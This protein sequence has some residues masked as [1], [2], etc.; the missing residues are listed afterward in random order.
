MRRRPF[1]QMTS[2][3]VGSAAMASQASAES[4]GSEDSNGSSL[5]EIHIVGTGG[6]IANPPGEGYYTAEELVEAR[7]QLADLASI[8]VTGVSRV[9]SQDITSEILFETYNVI[10]DLAENPNPP[11]GFVVTTGSNGNEEVGYFLNLALKTDIPVV[12][13]AAQRGVDSPGTD[14]DKNLLDAVRVASSTEAEGRGVLQVANDEIHHTRDVTKLVTTRPD[15]WESPN[16]GRVGMLD[17]GVFFYKSTDRLSTT[18]TEFDISKAEPKDYP[19]SGI[20]TVFSA[21]ESDATLVDA[22]VEADADGIVAVT[23]PTGSASDP[24]GTDS[25]RDGLLRA[26]EQGVPVVY[27]HRGIEG[28][29]TEDDED[30]PIIG[31]DTL[32]PQKA[33]LLLAFG[34]MKSSD[35]AYLQE[36]FLKY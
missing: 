13:T 14:S 17:G 5:P 20:K 24:E 22:A 8:S 7:P 10:M 3:A 12:M 26:A 29:V 1:L 36:L 32:R 34:V 4:E 31:A 30:D 27:S 35:P 25:Q 9:A 15:T 23:H 28:R 16:T 33:R 19:L 2:A 6:T 18:D 21:L 11:D